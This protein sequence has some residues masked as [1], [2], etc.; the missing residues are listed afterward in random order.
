MRRFILSSAPFVVVLLGGLL[1]LTMLPSGAAASPTS[2]ASTWTAA[3][4]PSPTTSNDVILYGMSCTS[5]S[6]CIAAGS[7]PASPVVEQWNGE[8]WALATLPSGTGGGFNGVSCVASSFCMAVGDDGPPGDG[9]VLTEEWNGSNWSE[10]PTPSLGGD[11]YSLVS[12]S[13]VSSTWCVAVG[14]EGAPCS[15]NNG[16]AA[17]GRWRTQPHPLVTTP[18]SSTA[19]IA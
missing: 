8:G 7:G 19:W 3:S 14:W 15:S 10:I 1:G 11:D 18:T 6:F 13:C 5:P 17:C 4:V 12:V 9:V 2:S 16:T